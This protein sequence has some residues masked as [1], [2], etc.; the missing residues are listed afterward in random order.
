MHV[1]SS[2]D[3]RLNALPSARTFDGYM[4]H[5]EELQEQLRDRAAEGAKSG[6]LAADLCQVSRLLVF[7]ALR[8]RVPDEV[9]RRLVNGMEETVRLLNE[10]WEHSGDE[11]AKIHQDHIKRR[12]D[13]LTF[14]QA[15]A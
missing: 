3:I 5:F 12:L 14:R 13:R 8:E 11:E 7:A 6:S 9:S 2:E 1:D 4:R 15:H 10:M